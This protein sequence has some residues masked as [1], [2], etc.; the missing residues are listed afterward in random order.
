MAGSEDGKRR[1]KEH[2]Y[3]RAAVLHPLRQRILRLTADGREASLAAISS[4]L[5]EPQGRVAYHLAVL[6]K[7]GALKIVADHAPAT[8]LYTWSSD[9][10]WARKMLDEIDARAAEDE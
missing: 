4:R 9:A 5:E 1:N 3:R 2:R 8:P 10:E 7:R 6:V